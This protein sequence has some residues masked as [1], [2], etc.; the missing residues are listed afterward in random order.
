MTALED[1]I[2]PNSGGGMFKLIAPR[3]SK[4]ICVAKSQSLFCTTNTKI[5]RYRL[6]LTSVSK[7]PNQLAADK[8][9][10]L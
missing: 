2:A 7:N 10:R 1:L 8:N 9:T 4:N 3:T 6:K 5:N